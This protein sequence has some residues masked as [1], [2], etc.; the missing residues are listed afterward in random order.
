MNK[1]FGYKSP[2]QLF[3][4]DPFTHYLSLRVVAYQGCLRILLLLLLDNLGVTNLVRL[5]L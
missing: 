2:E 3:V 4:I 5:L 1:S